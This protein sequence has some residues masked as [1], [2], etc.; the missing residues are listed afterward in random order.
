MKKAI[1]TAKIVP[2]G[3]SKGV[4]IPSFYFKQELI[5]TEKV[6]VEIKELKKG[7]K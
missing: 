6:I 4:I 5:T 1:F 3:T 7:G 2:I